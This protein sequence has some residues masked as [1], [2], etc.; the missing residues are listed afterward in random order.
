V[1]APIDPRVRER[2]Q[3]VARAAGRRRRRRIAQ[4]LVAAVVLGGAGGLAQSPLLDVD[5]VEV[6]GAA[7]TPASDVTRAA[8]LDRG[9]RPMVTLDRRAVAA[10]VEALPWV[11]TA[12]VERAWPSTVVVEVTERAAV[13][14]VP[15]TTGL[16]LVDADG[17]VV[18]V[19]TAAPAGVVAIA[20]PAR[21]RTPGTRADAAVLKA[22]EVVLALPQR[23][24]RQVRTVPVTGE[25]SAASVDLDL[26][27][28]VRVL[29]GQPA[30][31]TDKLRA[32][33]A[34][35]DAEKPPGGS[36]IDVRVP[37]SP[38]LRRPGGPAPRPAS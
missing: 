33:L 25:G 8:G 37:R 35:L 9:H 4:A 27:S 17:R 36:L 20:V 21:P 26:A 24:A 11:A 16:A 29:L 13:A 22:L 14:T 18:A 31:I 2:R 6:R 10:R 3:E 32:A 23:L 30:Q 12:R 38:T 28:G 15:T 34:V 1:G 5:R 7:H 19:A